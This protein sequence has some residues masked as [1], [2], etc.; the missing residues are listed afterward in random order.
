[1]SQRWKKWGTGVLAL[2]LFSFLSQMAAAAPLRIVID[3]FST[4]A[5]PIA[6]APFH[7]AGEGPAP[8]LDIADVIEKNMRRT[9][10]FEP[11]P[12]DD[13]LTQ[14]TFGTPVKFGHWRTIGVDY[15][16]LGRLTPHRD[17]QYLLEYELYDVYK[18]SRL[19]GYQ[20]P[21]PGARLHNA[22]HF[23][24]DL[25]YQDLTGRR[26]VFNTRIATVKVHTPNKGLPHYDLVIA[27]TDGR[28]E[29][30]QVSSSEPIMSPVFSPDQRRL[31][32]VSFQNDRSEIFVKDLYSDQIEKIASYPGINS[33]PAWSPDG[34]SLAFVLS[35]DG[36]PEIYVRDLRR[37]EL[38]RVTFNQ[39]IDTEP[40]WSPDGQSLVFTSDRGQGT[41]IYQTDVLGGGARRLTVEGSYNAC[42]KYS[43]DGRSL[44]FVH[45][46]ERGDFRIALMDLE[47]RR[48]RLLS[49]G[50]MD[51][52]PAFAPNG[53][54]ILYTSKEGQ[55]NILKTVSRNGRGQTVIRRDAE[56]RQP[57]W[58]TFLP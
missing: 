12:A 34:H 49:E 28:N 33:A 22:V 40:F 43:P 21:S 14:P 38:L 58:G 4:K 6:I 27:D 25:I 13:F 20:V 8:L 44:V 53:D 50:P 39:A 57:T 36:N 37:P 41:Q 30:M 52:S 55:Q 26:G 3:E 1:M 31:A 19:A 15:L 10:F 11:V 47:S 48:M 51:E 7:W 45:R 2:C 16:V 24:S 56:Y 9:G 54:M 46:D 5:Q 32:Y 23:L 42:A 17:G 18:G 35:K 29:Q